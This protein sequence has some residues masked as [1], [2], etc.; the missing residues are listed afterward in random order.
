MCDVF[1]WKV[2]EMQLEWGMGNGMGGYKKIYL[3]CFF[4]LWFFFRPKKESEE[5][6]EEEKEKEKFKYFLSFFLYRFF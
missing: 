3:T 6:E 5:S 4:F 2:V 1:D